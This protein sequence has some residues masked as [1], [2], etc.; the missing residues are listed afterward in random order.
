[1][2]P[3]GRSG[4]LARWYDAHGRH[5]LAWRTTRHRW[6]ILMSEILLHQTQVDRIRTAWPAFR[7]AFPTPRRMAARPVGDVLRLW[8]RLGYPR[9]ARALWRCAQIITNDGWPEDLRSLPGI[10]SYTAAA[11]RI[12][13]DDADLVAL[14]VNVRRV[15]ERVQG[16]RLPDRD[17]EAVIRRISRGM[18]PRDRLLALMDL[19]AMVCTARTPNCA[20]CPLRRRCATRGPLPES[21][22]RRAAPFAGSFR[23]Q[24]GQVLAALRNGATPITEFDATALDSLVRDGLAVIRTQRG[25][26]IAQLP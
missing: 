13:A 23:Q 3:S 14:D 6:L 9:R 10:G 4:P 21:S 8:D 1:M 7:R 11:V 5:D 24:R 16:Q 12:L 15:V 20:E 2:N 19:G 26:R 18:A 17:A 22:P 25:T